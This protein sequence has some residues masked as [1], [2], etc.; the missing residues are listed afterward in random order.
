[1]SAADDGPVYAVLLVDGI[2]DARRYTEYERLHDRAVF[3]AHGGELLVKSEAP[4]ILEGTWPHQRT[5]VLRFPSR[6]ALRAWY[7]S[8]HYAEVRGLRLEASEGRM[9]AFEA[10]G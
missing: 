10:Y 6:A 7:D 9:A 4:E 2:H 5:V 1:M 3:A 8:P